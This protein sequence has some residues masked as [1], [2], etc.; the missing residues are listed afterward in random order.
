MEENKSL[1]DSEL[2]RYEKQVKEIQDALESIKLMEIEDAEERL[3]A[4]IAKQNAM[5]KLPSLLNSLEELRSK[6]KLK[7][8]DVKGNRFLSP[9]EDGTLD[10]E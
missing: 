7:S 6:H 8:E 4:I 9:L 10:D 5:L 1:I 2:A 3:K